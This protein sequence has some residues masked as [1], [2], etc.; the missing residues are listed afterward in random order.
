MRKLRFPKNTWIAALTLAAG[1]ASERPRSTVVG[2]VDSQPAEML[3]AS[4][5]AADFDRRP[6]DTRREAPAAPNDADVVVTSFNE[7]EASGPVV[8]PEPDD[9]VRVVASSGLT[10]ASLESMA[11]RTN[12]AI[13]QA[14]ASAYKA[15]GFRDQVGLVPNPTLG[16]F[17]EQIGDAGTDQYGAFVSQD[18]VSAGKLTL[19]RNV[20]SHSVQAQLWEVDAQRY[21]VVTD[22]RLRFFDALA[23]QRRLELAT[24]F[25][26]VLTEG[27]RVA[28]IRKDAAEGSQ[29]EVL[30]AQLQLTELR[31]LKQRAGFSFQA[32]WKELAAVI[33]NSQL[34]PTSLETPMQTVPEPRNWDAVYQDVVS[35]SPELKA[36]NARVCRAA[37][38]VQRQETQPVPNLEVQAGV[39]HDLATDQQFGRVQAGLP[40]PIFNKNQGNIAAA[41][42]EYCRAQ[43]DYRRLQMSLSSRLAK[44]SQEFD[45]ARVAV[46]LYESQ[47]LPQADETLKLSE[48]AYAAGEFG[49]LQVLT[50]RRTYFDASLLLIDARRD[51]SQ[52]AALID[53]LLL[54]GGLNDTVDTPEDDGLRGQALSGQ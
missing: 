52:A 13:Q 29:P 10:L 32:A 42:A 1:C 20:L 30:L 17:G 21:R 27:V 45:S 8:P 50:A 25:E 47:V 18:F 53:G 19:N 46:E 26:L 6:C 3:A 38:N 43:Q 2:L 15:M 35:R 39:G 34:Q 22:V 28:R 37:A 31:V 48:K 23:A 36:A 12:P 14:S 33:G 11:L 40:I 41:D 54:S 24:D 9:A 4:S 5:T 7:D 16:F 49:F 51:L 44:A